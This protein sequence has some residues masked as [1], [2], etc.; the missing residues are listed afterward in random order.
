MIQNKS[1]EFNE[2]Y[3]I[4]HVSSMSKILISELNDQKVNSNL[5]V[6]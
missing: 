1:C 3:L 2:Y 5:I 6:E 4:K